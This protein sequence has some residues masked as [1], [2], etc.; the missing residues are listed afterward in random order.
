MLRIVICGLAALLFTLATYEAV[1]EKIDLRRYPPP[2][3]LVDV[4]GYALHVRCEGDGGPAVVFESGAGSTSAAWRLV[5][6]EVARFTRTCAYDRAGFGWS[7]SADGKPSVKASAEALH[8]LLHR[9]GVEPPYILVPHSLGGAVTMQ[10]AADYPGEVAGFVFVDAAYAELYERFLERFPEWGDRIGRTKLLLTAARS[11]AYLGLP[12]L[13]R[14]NTADPRLPQDEVGP[15]NAFGRTPRT[16]RAIRRDIDSLLNSRS[17]GAP[18]VPT[19]RPAAVVTHPGTALFKDAGPQALWLEMQQELA[20]RFGTDLRVVGDAGHFVQIDHPQAV[21]DAI[22]DVFDAI[23][24][25]RA[26]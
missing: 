23:V 24:T 10:F 5:Q 12:R 22:R 11:A 18:N 13:F 6:P 19:D 4:G 14:M 25:D 16:F 17:A 1:A 15:A 26:P 9:A 20:D 3:Q 2:G 8:T 21:N 7:E